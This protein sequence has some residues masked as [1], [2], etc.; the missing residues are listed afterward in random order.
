MG[1]ILS[2]AQLRALLLDE[3]PEGC[4]PAYCHLIHPARPAETLARQRCE[5]MWRLFAPLSDPGFADRLLPFDFH[6]RWFEMYLGATLVSAGLD[7]RAPTPGRGPDFEVSVDGRRVLIE[8]V[9]STA[10]DP[11]HADFVP[12]P[13]YRDAE[14]RSVCAQVPHDRITLRIATSVR[15]KL[16]AFDR[17]RVRN[18]VTPEDA[19]V[20]AVNLRDIPHAWA[21]PDESFF[22]AVYGAGDR[23][24]VVDAEACE[25]VAA[26]RNH[27]T[28][29]ARAGG[30]AEAVAPMLDSNHSDICAILGSSVDA[31][32]LQPPLGDDLVLMPHATPRAPFP[33]GLI[34]RGVEFSL[35]PG[36]ESGS[37]DVDQT[38]YGVP[39]PHGKEK[40]FVEFEG[41]ET[42]GEWE[43]SERELKVRVGGCGCS[44][45]FRKDSE[46]PAAAARAI[47][48][49]M[50]WA[51]ARRGPA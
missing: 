9:C 16:N 38:D 7:V 33:R 32:N 21:D 14:G 2:S 26:G 30:A 25:I 6:Q 49:E 4:D 22:R 35:R 5:E 11:N 48:R 24:Y 10:G 23:F 50:L 42:E 40:F 12:E 45:E 47:A 3:A 51:A 37:W 34:G 41:R 15:A 28:I 29:L 17:Y 27:R 46:D 31:W 20:V 13:V 19:C 1:N 8:A 44:I 18:L 39:E 43:I 36:D